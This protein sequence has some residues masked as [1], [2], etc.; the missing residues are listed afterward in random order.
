MALVLMWL[1]LRVL[2]W[3]VVDD[4]DEAEPSPA[5]ASAS[6]GFAQGPASSRAEG[7]A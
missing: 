1:E 2:S 6:P 5:F 4:D 3:L 7:G